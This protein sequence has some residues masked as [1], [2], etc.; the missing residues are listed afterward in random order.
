MQI[1]GTPA[2][3]ICSQSIGQ[4]IGQNIGRSINSILWST[5]RNNAGHSG[6]QEKLGNGGRG[7]D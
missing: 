3:I 2:T 7:K 5:H 1:G 6:R 4:S